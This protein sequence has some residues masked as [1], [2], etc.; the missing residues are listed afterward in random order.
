DALSA[1]GYSVETGFPPDG[2]LPGGRVMHRL[3]TP[4][5]AAPSLPDAALDGRW[6]E[7]SR[8]FAA[9]AAAAAATA[10]PLRP[11]ARAAESS[12][13]G[14]VGPARAEPGALRRPAAGR[15]ARRGRGAL[16]GPAAPVPL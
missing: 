9:A 3:T 16:W 15:R 4:S 5:E 14:P 7:A 11:P 13:P 10:P 8:R 1:L 2:P 6:M 12:P